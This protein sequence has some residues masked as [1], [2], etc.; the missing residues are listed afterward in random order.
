MNGVMTPGV[1]AGSN[2]VGASETCTAKVICPSGAADAGRASETL[3]AT[4]TAHTSALWTR[5]IISS[6]REA[7]HWRDRGARPRRDGGAPTGASR[8]DW[9]IA[10]RRAEA[11]W[12]TMP[13][14]A[15]H[16]AKPLPT[17]RKERPMILERFKVPE[18]DQVLVS[19]AALRRT[20]AQIF[21]KLGVTPEDAA[22]GADVL[23]MTDL[24]GVETHGVSNMLRMYVRNYRGGL[25]DP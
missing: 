19:E 14:A 22:I 13:G 5:V 12:S 3:R 2:H 20:I 7:L 6:I 25:L 15:R 24:R 16:A 9:V 21:E 18:H 8:T 11:K 10:T 1:S 23:T 4:R 17:R